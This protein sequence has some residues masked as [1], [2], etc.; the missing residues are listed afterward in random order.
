[1]KDF[2]EMVSKHRELDEELH[3]YISNILH[4]Y[5]IDMNIK[6][7]YIEYFEWEECIDG[8]LI[9]GY[10]QYDTEETLKIPIQFFVDYGKAIKEYREEQKRLKEKRKLI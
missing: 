10:T 5:Y 1:M 9:S 2:K 6:I 3:D 7:K 8:I 4:I